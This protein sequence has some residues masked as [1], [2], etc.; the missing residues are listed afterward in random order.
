MKTVATIKGPSKRTAK[1]AKVIRLVPKSKATTASTGVE[2][3]CLRCGF[4]AAELS[5]RE[6][7]ICAEAG[8][9]PK[10]FAALKAK[11]GEAFHGKRTSETDAAYALRWRHRQAVATLKGI[12]ST[13]EDHA[14]F[15]D[16]T[17]D[18]AGMR[19]WIE[20][21]I[22]AA[23]EARRALEQKAPHAT[24]RNRIE[25]AKHALERF[26]KLTYESGEPWHAQVKAELAFTEAVRHDPALAAIP[27]ARWIRAVESWPGMV[28]RKRGDR[29]RKGAAKKLSCWDVLHDLLGNLSGASS[30]RR[31]KE[32]YTRR[33]FQMPR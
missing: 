28:E 18:N 20:S 11:S 4:V 13:L 12:V 24:Q 17:E 29:E 8:T 10:K 5:A 26:S 30:A 25:A 31:L 7:A 19:A 16:G 1:P 3:A 15:V 32:T 9:D 27:L 33:E 2:G 23:E 21:H 22:H 6:L 14:R